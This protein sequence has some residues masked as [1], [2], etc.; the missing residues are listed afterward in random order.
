MDSDGADA[1]F[2]AVLRD[3]GGD[4]GLFGAGGKAVG[5][6]FDVAA[7]DDFAGFEED[8]G[9]DEEVAVGSVGVVGDPLGVAGEFGELGLGGRPFAGL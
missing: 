5:G 8:C 4:R 2:G 7:G 3:G 1:D 6:V 9:A